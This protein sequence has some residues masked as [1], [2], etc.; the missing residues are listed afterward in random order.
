VLLLK[1]VFDYDH[2][3]IAEILDMSP[4]NSRQLLHRAKARIAQGRPRLS[5]T[6]ES[7]R[8]VA[9]RFARAFVSG[10]ADRLV[11]LLADDVGLWSDG[12][13]KAIAARRP[14]LGRDS[15]VNMLV[16]LER[17]ARANGMAN[18]SELKIEEVNAEPALVLRVAGRLESIF[19][20]S[21]AGETV[22][23]IRVVRNPDKL[24]RINRQL[25][26]VH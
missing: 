12:G 26:S 7:R 6:P 25:T 14:I 8:A 19:V 5:G 9:E 15:V 2:V 21:I 20:L 1:D 13:G 22:T 17:S 16:G 23:G 24:D 10:D 18:V 11:A 4:D 3:A